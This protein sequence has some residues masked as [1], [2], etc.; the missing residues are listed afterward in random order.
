MERISKNIRENS[1]KFCISINLID[2]EKLNLKKLTLSQEKRNLKTNNP[3][4]IK[5]LSSVEFNRS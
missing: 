4:K 3:L 1:Y 2:A 5:V